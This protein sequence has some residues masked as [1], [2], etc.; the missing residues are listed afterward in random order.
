MV[1][2]Q[3]QLALL[4]LWRGV[5]KSCSW[6]RPIYFGLELQGKP[7]FKGDPCGLPEPHKSMLAKCGY[8][9]IIQEAHQQYCHAPNQQQSQNLKSC[10]GQGNAFATLTGSRPQMYCKSKRKRTWVLLTELV[11]R[12]LY[13]ALAM[14]VFQS[15]HNCNIRYA[16]L[17]KDKGPAPY[18]LMEQ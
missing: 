14:K 1:K 9:G 8:R 17:S 3:T 18:H 16:L 13:N 2:K 12:A 6:L 5:G 15:N 7:R 10:H 11:T 4:G